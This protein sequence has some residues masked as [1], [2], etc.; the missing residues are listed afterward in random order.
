MC[1]TEL[2]PGDKTCPSCGAGTLPPPIVG[3][4][5]YASP[6]VADDDAPSRWPV[7]LSVLGIIGALIVIV[8]AVAPFFKNRNDEIAI[9]PDSTAGGV[10][11]VPPV[12]TAPVTPAPETLPPETAPPAVA[13]APPGP[14]VPA[15]IEASCTARGSTDSKG[16][17][18]SFRPENTADGDPSTA[19][20][21]DGDA[22][23]QTITYAFGQPANVVQVAM[24]PGYAK[25]DEFNGDDRFVENRR[26]TSAVWHC[27]D[28]NAVE[29]ASLPQTFAD[30]RDLQPL[31]TPGFVGCQIIR[32]E[33]TGATAAGRRDYTAISEASFTAG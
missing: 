13:V 31:A 11:L 28:V 33:I 15:L 4:A 2:D 14:I 8:L 19:W 20:R 5:R 25:I 3:D 32:L 9:V 21:C 16:N 30:S 22:A 23:G 27:L 18:I 12:D 10:T 7:I 6:R 29:V 17:P 1:G 24:I 26:V